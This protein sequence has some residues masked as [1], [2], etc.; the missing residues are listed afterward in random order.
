MSDCINCE[1]LKSEIAI[2]I[3]ERDAEK[4]GRIN[5]TKWGNK[6]RA[7]RDEARAALARM[8]VRK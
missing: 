5:A 4:R 2:L 8:E 3:A 6:R 1:R 7:E